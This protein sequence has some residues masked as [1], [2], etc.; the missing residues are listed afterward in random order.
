MTHV[1]LSLISDSTTL[2]A[3]NQ[4]PIALS[5]FSSLCPVVTPVPR[6]ECHLF[7][8]MST[9]CSGHTRDDGVDQRLT[10]SSFYFSSLV[11]DK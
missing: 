7:V 4:N 11:L 2:Y 5:H 10:L 8:F 3:H 1:S 6:Q 9:T